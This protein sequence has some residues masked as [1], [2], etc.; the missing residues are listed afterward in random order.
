MANT[1]KL[2][3]KDVNSTADT[4]VGEI[5]SIFFDPASTQLRIGDG[6]TPG[7][8]LIGG[9]ST[10]GDVTYSLGVNNTITGT[11][12]STHYG[13]NPDGEST[14]DIYVFRSG[15]IN[16]WCVYLQLS[17]AQTPISYNF[18]GTLTSNTVI[19]PIRGSGT[20]NIAGPAQAQIPGNWE[21]G[22]LAVNGDAVSVVLT[23]TDSTSLV[24]VYRVEMYLTS[25]TTYVATITKKLEFNN[26]F[27][28]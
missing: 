17:T 9:G 7:G 14:H 8:N 23:V 22:V 19:T 4:Y 25:T 1:R 2:H 18:F 21:G 6:T 11:G 5:G 24:T 26:S 10:T 15:S 13:N 28:A 27:P 20:L 3:Y 16:A 12:A